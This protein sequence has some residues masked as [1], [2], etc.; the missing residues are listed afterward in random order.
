M[1]GL[2]LEE[3]SDASRRVHVNEC[4]DQASIERALQTKQTNQGAT[5]KS[6][7][8]HSQVCPICS[9]DAS[10][11]SQAQFEVHVY[12][13]LDDGP[14][15]TELKEMPTQIAP[16]CDS[17][18]MSMPQISHSSDFAAASNI[19]SP[20]RYEC[21]FC[22]KDL[23]GVDFCFRVRHLKTC[24]SKNVAESGRDQVQV[25]QA[26]AQSP[27]NIHKTSRAAWK[28]I[29]D[30]WRAS[31]APGGSGR[32]GRGRGTRR[33]GGRGG[34]RGRG[35]GRGWGRPRGTRIPFWKRIE[36]THF[37]VD[38]FTYAGLCKPGKRF[39]FFLTHFHS[40]HYGGIT[41]KFDRGP[42]YCTHV[43]ARL[44]KKH[45]GLSPNVHPVHFDTPIVID[46]VT[47]TFLDA[48]HC[49]GSAMI[50]F[51]QGM[52]KTLHVG[53]FRFCPRMR[54][55]PA[56]AQ[57]APGELELCYLDTT[58]AN[59]RHR[60]PPQNECVEYIASQVD[61][62]TAAEPRLLVVVGA[63]TIG[64]ERVQLA[65]AERCGFKIFVDRQRYRVYSLLDLPL[66][67][68]VGT[69]KKR[70]GKFSGPRLR[71]TSLDRF[72]RPPAPPKHVLVD[73]TNRS[74]SQPPGRSKILTD[75]T[76]VGKQETC[77]QSRFRGGG[78]SV[79]GPGFRLFE[80]LSPQEM[81][82]ISARKS[83][84]QH[85]VASQQA[86]GQTDPRVGRPEP[87]AAK[88]EA[89]STD[90]QEA[91]RQRHPRTVFSDVYTTDKSASRVHVVPMSWISKDR[92]AEYLQK[93]NASRARG[94]KY[95][96]VL[97]VRPT[98]W[99]GNSPS[100]QSHSNGV[101]V[102]SVPYSEHSTCE[103]L[104]SFISWLRPQRIIP[105]VNV[106]KAKATVAL[107][108]SAA[109]GRTN[110]LLARANPRNE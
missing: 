5:A 37:I 77:S 45:F 99:A 46:G 98:G 101:T 43:T 83:M 75:D 68:Q 76:K 47:V 38:G 66:P 27:Q 105:T 25:A 50:L 71:T 104:R 94:R 95:T 92:L 102:L 90:K 35:W 87:P 24:P 103:E 29:L 85:L 79:D 109:K 80:K 89:K 44:L 62:A 2:G 18:S 15:S 26:G 13:C 63:Y 97:G 28:S 12:G 106:K 52:C 41:R 84:N 19:A 86:S 110:A 72:L 61:K 70:H 60:F 11:L 91:R 30:G 48:C 57:L 82:A 7:S 64:K 22:S 55:I 10:G 23:T 69:P 107:L 6:H 4:L 73:S 108:R 17:E 16:S 49:P 14:A 20:G 96:G 31:G 3:R 58:Y 78:V 93:C 59:P 39:V 36:N 9:F 21:P 8:S 54:E 67:E 34:G 1:C 40:D 74:P 56:L 51:Q 65:I 42:I 81:D 33:G 53:D 100:R 32:R 88:S